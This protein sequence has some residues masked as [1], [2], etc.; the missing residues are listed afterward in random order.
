[1]LE[2]KFRILTTFLLS[3]ILI[4]PQT[5]LANELTTENG[6]II[7][8]FSDVKSSSKYFVE[9]N[10]LAEQGFFEGY[11]DGT[12]KANQD[13]NRAE[14]LKI[15]L[16]TSGAVNKDN[17]NEYKE[18]S[19]FLD[20]EDNAWYA[21]YINYAKQAEIVK[22][23]DDG[24][25]KP[26][27]NITLVTALKI[28]LESY[29]NISYP[30][31]FKNHFADVDE[32]EWYAK[33][34]R[35]ADQFDLMEIYPSNSIYPNQ[36]LN[37]GDLAGLV[38]RK[39]MSEKGNIEF[40]KATFYGK[41]VQGHYT[42]SGEIFDL[43]KFT[44]AHKTLPFGSIVEVTNLANGK[45]TQVRITDRGPYGPGRVIDLTEAAFS[46]IAWLGSGVIHIQL[47]VI[48]NPKDE[49]IEEIQNP[50]EEVPP[51]FS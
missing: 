12:F 49:I 6:E 3:L 29:K 7:S 23:F 51:L 46:D 33:Y 16:L 20:I 14:A 10:Y 11:P 27:E 13:V 1:M 32:N 35:Y 2:K 34:L 19:E 39:I 48:Y 21:P 31:E 38:Y 9:I 50:I 41:A 18:G 24:N 36:T 17:I 44:A 43:N 8:R 4:I 28:Y 15:L 37:R 45:K 25:F 5:T 42:A 26:G 47:E 22:G 40:G 30:E